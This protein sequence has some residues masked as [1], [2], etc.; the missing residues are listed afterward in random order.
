MVE[1]SIVFP[2]LR[3]RHRAQTDHE[4]LTLCLLYVRCMLLAAPHEAER[5]R[6]GT[7]L[8]ASGRVGASP[9]SAAVGCC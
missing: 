1:N 3:C 7:T 2:L 4:M 5:E 6:E 8:A 9:A